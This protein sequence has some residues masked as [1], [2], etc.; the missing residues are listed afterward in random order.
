MAIKDHKAYIEAR[1]KRTKGGCWEWQGTMNHQLGYGCGY[2]QGEK[3][4][5]H[6]LSYIVHVGEI[7]PG[8]VIC[9][10]CDNRR[11]VNPAHLVAGTQKRNMAGCAYRYRAGGQRLRRED[12]AEI[13]RLH[14]E[15]IVR[16]AEIGERFGISAGYV[17]D[18]GK[19]RKK[20]PAEWVDEPAQG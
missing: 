14:D 8:A 6:R 4:G 18:I 10:E 2:Y 9:H 11:C 3:I 17:R 5:A 12:Y 7:P 15:G 19:G 1:I 20:P 13:A 16:Q